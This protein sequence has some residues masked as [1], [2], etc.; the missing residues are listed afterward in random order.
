MLNVKL[1]F[2]SNEQKCR[3]CIMTY[4]R[5]KGRKNKKEKE[6]IDFSPIKLLFKDEDKK[7]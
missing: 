1:E 6:S 3:S 7:L 5:V 4:T 2:F